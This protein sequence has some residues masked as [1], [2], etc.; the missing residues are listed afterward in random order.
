MHALKGVQDVTYLSIVQ[1]L[2]LI[3]LLILTV[4]ECSRTLASLVR[5]AFGGCWWRLNLTLF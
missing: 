1:L 4:G 5:F 3:S 2:F